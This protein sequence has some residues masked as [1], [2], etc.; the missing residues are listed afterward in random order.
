MVQWV[1]HK[2]HLNVDPQQ[3][4]EAS[5]RAVCTCKPV[6]GRA[7]A[8]RLGVCWPASLANV[9]APGSVRVW[10]RSE[11]PLWQCAQ[12][13]YKCKPDKIQP[14][15]EVDVKHN[16]Y[17]RSYLAFNCCWMTVRFLRWLWPLAYQP[18]SRAS[19]M[20]R[21]F[22][23]NQKTETCFLGLG[24]S[25]GRWSGQDGMN[26]I[27]IQHIKFSNKLKHFKKRVLEKIYFIFKKWGGVLQRK[28][29]SM[30]DPPPSHPHPSPPPT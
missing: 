26:M 5:D 13:L 9:R 6:T 19:F 28:H 3:P 24:Y 22:L 2:E 1:K 29:P 12:E 8:D 23:A 4:W 20:P 14:V 10:K 21:S 27:K 18:H 7:K 11:K 25:T 15:A 16:S 17:L 30:S